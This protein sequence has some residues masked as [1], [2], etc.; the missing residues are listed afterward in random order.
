MRRTYIAATQATALVLTTIVL[1]LSSD[2]SGSSIIPPSHAE[3]SKWNDLQTETFREGKVPPRSLRQSQDRPSAQN[4]QRAPDTVYAGMMKILQR[5][6]RDKGVYAGPVDGVCNPSIIQAMRWS[7]CDITG[8]HFASLKLQQA[9]GAGLV[10]SLGLRP[11]LYSDMERVESRCNLR[12]G[13]LT[14]YIG[15][16]IKQVQF[17]FESMAHVGPEYNTR[18]AY[19][20]AE[21][22]E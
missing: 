19:C 20:I 11:F 9:S 5:G 14:Q 1:P 22:L 17:W 8:V 7:T 6:L 12:E 15:V 16:W 4:R 21:M 13:Q 2:W 10:R 18:A 3:V